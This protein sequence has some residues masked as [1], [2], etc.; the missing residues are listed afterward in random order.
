LSPTPIKES[1]RKRFMPYDLPKRDP[2]KVKALAKAVRDMTAGMRTADVVQALAS[3]IT[4]AVCDTS[5]NR[6]TARAIVEAM[7]EEML[8]A[9]DE[10]E[11]PGWPTAR[12]Q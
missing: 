7:G 11:R 12:R 5:G 3:V 8:S 10:A 4:T 6:D 9:V 1:R 2:A